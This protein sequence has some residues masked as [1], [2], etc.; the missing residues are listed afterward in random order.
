MAPRSVVRCSVT[1]GETHASRRTF[2]YS[3]SVNSNRTTPPRAR[4]S[5]EAE[6]SQGLLTASIETHR[7]EELA[8]CVHRIASAF[9]DRHH[10]RLPRKE[11]PHRID[12][13]RARSIASVRRRDPPNCAGYS[14]AAAFR[15][16]LSSARSPARARRRAPTGVHVSRKPDDLAEAVAAYATPPSAAP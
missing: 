12:C 1:L 13:G 15:A 16:L 3:L 8:R 5:P 7:A 4:N 2:A 9:E 6:A 14:E 11:R 10:R